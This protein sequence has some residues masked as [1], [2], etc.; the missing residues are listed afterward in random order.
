MVH[1]C[2]PLQVLGQPDCPYSDPAR[3]PPEDNFSI[4]SPVIQYGNLQNVRLMTMLCCPK[5]FSMSHWLF[6]NKAA[7]VPYRLMSDDSKE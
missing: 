5:L 3:S 1:E 2:S 6:G 7:A 4:C